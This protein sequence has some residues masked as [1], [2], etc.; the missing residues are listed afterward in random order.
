[1]EAYLATRKNEFESASLQ[2]LHSIL[3]LANARGNREYLRGV[4]KSF[5]WLEGLTFNVKDI[6]AQ[7]SACDGDY[8]RA[9][10]C[11]TSKNELLSEESRNLISDHLPKLSERLDF[12]TF[13]DAAF[14]WLDKLPDIV[15][16]ERGVFDEYTEERNTWHNLVNDISAQFGKEE[17]TL[18]LLL[19]ELDLRSKTPPHPQN[20]VPCFTIHSSKGME[21]D[22]VYL[23]GLVEDQLPSWQAK[24]KGNDS[25]EMREERRSC[26]V[27]ITRAQEFL[28]LSCAKQVQGWEKEPSRFLTEMGLQV[29][30]AAESFA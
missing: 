10:M 11:V 18:N 9:W 13:Q 15:P 21:F 28:S 16:N 23:V 24:R 17:V 30:V 4:C 19:Q 2:W 7:A 26:F 8:L 12:W 3:R 27:A 5:Y 29:A 6:A 14:K 1:M 25:R 20:A 22:H